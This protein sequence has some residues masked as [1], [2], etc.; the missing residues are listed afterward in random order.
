MTT[1]T[2][3]PV[4]VLGAG[5]AGL[6]AA[7]ELRRH[8]FDVIV[9][10]AGPRIAGLAASHADAEGFRYDTGA[11]FITN[12]LA[13]AAGAGDVC[14]PIERYGEAV[15]LR[16]R[17]IGYPTG[18]A[19]VPRFAAAAA[20]ARWR[21]SSAE[22]STAAEAF[23]REYG[24]ALADEVALPLVE[25]WSGA[26]A[27]ELSPA[28]AAKFAGGIGHL[29]WLH[30]ASRITRRVVASGY[31]RELPESAAVTHV[32][33]EEGVAAVCRRVADGLDDAVRLESRVEKIYVEDGR[34]VGIRA[35]GVDSPAT[36]VVTTAPVDV[37]PRLVDGT[38]VLDHLGGF[39][40]RAM[41][42]VNLKLRGRALLPDVVTWLP[43]AASAAFRLTEAPLAMPWLA[44]AGKTVITCDLGAEV[45]DPTW[46]A[47]DDALVQRCL[48][49]LAALV[50]D[51]RARLLGSAVLRVRY[52]YPMFLTA[53]EPARQA[54][55]QGSGVTD[56]LSV[57]RNGEFAHI[58]MEDVYW[59]TV[60]RIHGWLRCASG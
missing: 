35:G 43:E 45:G 18:L 44:P 8:G 5:I 3:P 42:F 2:Q 49:D 59:R 32:Y 38:T 1:V 36:A 47:D 10:E 46:A 29:L 22:P 17:A 6:V 4:A 41:V 16:G 15:W 19:T 58:L 12:R 27:D 21:R 13:A 23:R 51:V 31:C 53:Y 50:P 26:S 48:D 33:P 57:G 52:A 7:R 20:K 30:V 37:L 55:E 39:R 9:H 56:L 11:H 40:Y 14:R 28:V 34:A 24:A 25:A 54:W 60:R